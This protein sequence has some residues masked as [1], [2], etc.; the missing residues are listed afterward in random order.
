MVAHLC[1]YGLQTHGFD[2]RAMP[3]MKPTRFL[4]SVPDLLKLLG[5]QC[6]QEHEHSLPLEVAPRQ[7]P[8]TRRHSAGQCSGASRFKGAVKENQC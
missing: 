8:S 4:S 6:S 5:M 3:A 7:Q 2:G 1:K